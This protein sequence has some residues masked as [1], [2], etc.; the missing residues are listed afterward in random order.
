MAEENPATYARRF[1]TFDASDPND[2]QQKLQGL[3]AA[4]FG[5]AEYKAQ[6]DN[7]IG[8]LRIQIDQ[9][10]ASLY[11]QYREEKERG[12][13]LTEASIEAMIK[14]DA[15][16]GSMWARLAALETSARL[17]FDL[18]DSLR[19]ASRH[20]QVVVGNQQSERMM[21]GRS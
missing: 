8:G 12:A 15:T 3:P 21:A 11:G 14:I 7:Q 5:L 20:L 6:V 9:R 13:K 2:V 19:M 1:L 4:Y 10:K 18:M 17:L 16:L